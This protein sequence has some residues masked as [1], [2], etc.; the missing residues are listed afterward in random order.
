M[1]GHHD[2]TNIC[3]ISRPSEER[4]EHMHQE[5]VQRWMVKMG[6][7]KACTKYMAGV[8]SDSCSVEDLRWA[9]DITSQDFTMEDA[10]R[11]CTLLGEAHNQFWNERDIL[12]N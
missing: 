12:G 11:L 7:P 9:C 3:T 4:K 2:V 5:C 1:L 6:S 10:G 8:A